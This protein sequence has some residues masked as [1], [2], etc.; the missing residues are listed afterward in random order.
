MMIEWLIHALPG[1]SKD[2]YWKKEKKLILFIP[3]E[4]VAK[5]V[6]FNSVQ[7]KKLLHRINRCKGK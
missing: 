4:K 2:W 5:S 6:K 3:S 7:F 1:M